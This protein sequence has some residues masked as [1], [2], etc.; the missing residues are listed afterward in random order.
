MLILN[1]HYGSILQLM[2]IKGDTFSWIYK[3]SVRHFILNPLYYEVSL[4]VLSVFVND[5]IF[6]FISLSSSTV[7]LFF[8][9]SI[10]ED[11]FLDITVV[12]IFRLSI[13][14]YYSYIIIR[15]ILNN[16]SVINEND[17]SSFS[18]RTILCFN[19]SRIL[20]INPDF[21]IS[22][23]RRDYELS[24]VDKYTEGILETR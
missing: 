7:L 5:S 8:I 19:R 6:L 16:Y 15:Y 2:C 1:K 10:R 24:P 17:W 14:M 4:K 3:Y 18:S 13:L 11:I 20:L 23:K 9:N 21:F 12:H 22:L